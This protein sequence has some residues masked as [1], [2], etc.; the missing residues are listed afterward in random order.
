[1]DFWR[2]LGGAVVG[3]L[4]GGIPGAIAGGIGG[5]SG[6][7]GTAGRVASGVMSAAQAAHQAELERKAD[8]YA[9]AGWDISKGNWDANDPLRQ[10]GRGIMLNPG[11]PNMSGL[12]AI[13]GMIPGGLPMGAQTLSG[14][15]SALARPPMPVGGLGGPVAPPSGPAQ[16]PGLAGE[17]EN[18]L[19][20]LMGPGGQAKVDAGFALGERMKERM[21]HDNPFIKGDETAP[22]NPN[23]RPP[24]GLSV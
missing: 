17:Q 3:G 1:M 14:A 13:R 18:W 15:S 23:M 11:T 20:K 4:T 22:A 5:L 21:R 2:G 19:Q 16:T 12:D 6:G 7:G 10:M 9:Q 24:T 8:K